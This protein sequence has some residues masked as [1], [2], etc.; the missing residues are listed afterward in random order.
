MSQKKAKKTKNHK[1]PK[2][3]FKMVLYNFKD[4]EELYYKR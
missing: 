3:E 1:K 2:P 4:L